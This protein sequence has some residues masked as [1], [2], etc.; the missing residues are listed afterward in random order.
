MTLPNGRNELDYLPNRL[1]ITAK[2]QRTIQV[3][4]D[5]L[6]KEAPAE[7]VFIADRNGQVV[8]SSGDF[9]RDRLGELGALLAGD[10]A[11]NAEIARLIG[12]KQENQLILRENEGEHS[13]ISEAGD[14]LILFVL[15]SSDVPLGWARLLIQQVGKELAMSVQN[16]SNGH[17]AEDFNL[18]SQAAGQ[19]LE[20]NI[21]SL[22]S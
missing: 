20:D 21:D 15:T 9:D 8:A 1:S 4:G 10:L 19:D 2:Q 5:K 3:L 14:Y 6:K 12:S 13:F 7:L 22:W 17:A 16:S 11:A 18:G